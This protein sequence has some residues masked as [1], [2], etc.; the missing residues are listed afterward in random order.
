MARGTRMT[1]HDLYHH[2]FNRGNDKHPIF[3]RENDYKR[4]VRYLQIFSRKHQIRIIA[5]ALMEWHIHLFLYDKS[6]ELSSFMHRL[7]GKYARLYN[8]HYDRTGHVFGCRFRNKIIDTNR[9]GTWLSRYIHRQAVD[10]GIV[11]KV[12]DYEWTSYQHYIGQK[13]ESFLYSSII[14]GQFGETEGMQIA[15]YRD[16]V[17]SDEEGPIDW[18]QT[19][20][21]ANLIIGNEEFTKNISR[22][23][24]IH[25]VKSCDFHE[26][27]ERISNE[28][29]INIDIIRNPSGRQ[30]R[31]TRH[32]L[33]RMLNYNHGLS[34]SAIAEGLDVSKATVSRIIRQK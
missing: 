30:E 7:H 15:S 28:Y 13:H 34:V 23:L 24:G 12:D 5:Y 8:I 27:I 6:G 21:N 14:L 25:E 10:A 32:Y 19:E 26:T 22:K 18:K 3:K 11:D 20:S 1:G 2:V 4:Y 9:Y 29:G 31:T 33:I 17:G 16:F